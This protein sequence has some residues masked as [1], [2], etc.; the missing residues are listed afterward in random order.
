[1]NAIYGVGLN[2]AGYVVMRR[3][4][5][6]GKRKMVWRCPFYVVWTSMLERCYSQTFQRKRPSYVGCSVTLEWLR[7]SVFRAWML[8]QDWVG[9]DLDKDLIVPG[10]RVYGPKTCV[11]ISAQVN[12]FIVEPRVKKSEW[13]LGVS[14]HELGRFRADCQNPETGRCEY[15]GLFDCP[16]QAHDAWKARKL[17]HA[18]TLA[19]RQT[20]ER[21][22]MA[23]VA[24]YC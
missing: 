14:R 6:D 10:N 1:M 21:V 22:A 24:R 4:V 5:I 9:K 16:D 18:L 13:P 3:A 17:E 20:D 15:V 2:D 7:F 23:L 12:C 8:T 19:S 11:F